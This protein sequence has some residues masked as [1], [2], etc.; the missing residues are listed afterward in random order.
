[1]VYIALAALILPSL[2]RFLWFYRGIPARQEIATPD[3]QSFTAP[4]PPEGNTASASTEKVKQFGGTAILDLAHVNQFQ[5][6]DIASLTDQIE[7]RGGKVETITDA[8]TLETKLKYASAFITVSP[9]TAF[10]ADEIRLL[11]AFV[12]RGGRLMVFADAT[13]NTFGF[14]AISGNLIGFGDVNAVNPLLAP[15]DI[16]I[17][18][19]YLYNTSTNEGNFRNIVFDNFGKSELTFGLKEVTFYGTHSVQTSS[20]LIL[21][22]GAESTLSSIDDANN[23]SA[24]GAALSEDGNVA[25]F[26]DF[27]FLTSPYDAYADNA[28]LI[29]NLADF[30]LDGKRDTTLANFPYIYSNNTVQVFPTSELQM[31]PELISALSR[32][33]Y[34]L[35]YINVS[36]EIAKKAPHNGDSIILGTFTPSD[37]LTDYTDPFRLEFDDENDTVSVQGLGTMNRTGNGLILFER[38][39]NGVTLTLLS[40]TPENLITLLDTVGSGSLY[41]CVIQKEVAACGV[42]Y[43]DSSSS[44]DFTENGL[45]TEVPAADSTT[46]SPAPAGQFKP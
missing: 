26:G 11:K 1:M 24:G 28:A 23:P 44:S 46:A 43:S 13:R 32:L 39:L 30:A 41:S 36:M 17:N 7:K 3:Y 8:T 9:S 38:G 15:F 5:P 42:G 37:D 21:L 16:T 10:T 14:D 4:Q 29:A 45:A 34:S 25:A 22:Q 27:T 35:Q 40:D 33:Q 19:D 20:G 18:N 31:T 2:A 12:E 6:S